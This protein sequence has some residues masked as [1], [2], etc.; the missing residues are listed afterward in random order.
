VDAPL[1]G[2][3][4][5]KTALAAVKRIRAWL[6]LRALKVRPAQWAS[7]AQSAP[8]ACRAPAW[9]A[10]PVKR[11]SP[12]PPG[13][14]AQWAKQVQQEMLQSDAPALPGLP[15]PEAFKAPADTRGSKALA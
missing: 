15:A 9:L 4:S 8:P 7:K 14:K 2:S 11:V 6:A 10:L 3:L 12:V 5:R 13:S 1:P